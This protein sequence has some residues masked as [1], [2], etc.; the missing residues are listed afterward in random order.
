MD[1]K[2]WIPLIATILNLYLTHRQVR[3]MEAQPNAARL[4]SLF[5]AG[6]ALL[7]YWPIGAM[8]VLMLLCW[9]P[10]FLG[11]NAP[12]PSYFMQWRLREEGGVGATIDTT[13]LESV[14]GKRRIM[15]AA[16]MTSPTVDVMDNPEII[17]SRTYEIETPILQIDAIATPEFHQKEYLGQSIQS[18]LIEVPENFA[19]E[20]MATVADAER[21]GGK[22]LERKGFGVRGALT[23]MPQAR[24][25]SAQ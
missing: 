8:I 1:Y 9:V 21:L 23:T 6:K 15:I 7:R 5:P 14:K 10:Y 2:F 11:P 25:P 20:K 18:F 24:Q 3:F 12:P 19:I 4:P 22:V 13:S 16:V 17:K